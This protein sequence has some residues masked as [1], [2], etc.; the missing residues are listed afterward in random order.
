MKRNRLGRTGIVVTDICMGTMTFGLQADEEISFE[1]MD[2]ALDAGI[3]FFDTAE[4]YPVP[5]SAE[6]Y[7]VTEQIVGKWLK[8]Q[9]RGEIIIA[10]KVTGPGHGWFRPPVRNGQ[11]RL[12]FFRTRA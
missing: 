6:L 4:L 3:D 8:G 2:R 11:S 12:I 10:S 1:I 9:T 5:P 7:G